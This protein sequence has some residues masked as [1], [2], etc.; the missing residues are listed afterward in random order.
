MATNEPLTARQRRIIHRCKQR[1]WLELDVILGSWAAKYVP[2]MKDDEEIEQVE[3]LLEAE[4]PHLYQW[5]IGNAKPHPYFDNEA[6]K[7]VQDFVAGK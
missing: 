5:I 2:R 6:F 4:T 7:S 1:G 3:R